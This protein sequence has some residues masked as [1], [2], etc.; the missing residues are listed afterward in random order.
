MSDQRDVDDI[1]EATA[2]EAT[3]GAIEENGE[4]T[5]PTPGVIEGN[6]E[7]TADELA[8]GEAGVARRVARW[9]ATEWVSLTAALFLVGA[10]ALAGALYWYQYRLDR[11][12]NDSAA[13]AAIAAASDGTVA[14]LSYSPDS[15]DH[16][17]S[18]AKAHLT[19]DF[20]SYYNQFT[21]EIVTPA[22]KQ[23]GVKTSAA[24]IQSAVSELHPDRAV[25]LL[26]L[27]Q[28][29]SS[30]DKPEPALT[31]SSVLVTLTKVNGTW[32][33]SKFDPV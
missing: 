29:T 27:N 19:G 7:T 8:V 31:A 23:K 25:V 6:R 33:I 11:A 28:S 4:A 2:E 9:C 16:D 20:L 32:L 5:E 10:L 15:L 12:T 14:L 30:T 3:P 13:R 18:A 21:R 26:F 24:V 17:F 22:A 1:E